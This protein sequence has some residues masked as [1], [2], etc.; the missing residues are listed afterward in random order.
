MDCDISELMN[1][2]VKSYNISSDFPDDR[3]KSAPP[4]LSKTP[5]L[6][7]GD[8]IPT[9][10]TSSNTDTKPPPPP[11]LSEAEDNSLNTI[12]T[13]V[14]SD[15]V[16]DVMDDP[17]PP[18]QT[19]QSAP[20]VPAYPAPL[21]DPVCTSAAED[22]TNKNEA[23]ETT[24]EEGK[25]EEVKAENAASCSDS[26]STTNGV[27]DVET[28]QLSV[29]SPPS[30]QLETPPE[31]PIAQPEE[32]CLPNG[33]PLPAPQDPEVSNISTVERDDSPIAEPEISQEPILQTPTAVTQK[34]PVPV[35]QAVPE[36]VDPP[37]PAVQEIP[38]DPVVQAPPTPPEVQDTVPPVDMDIEENTP[39]PQSAAKEEKPSPEE[40]VSIADTTSETVPTSSPPTAE[41]REN[42]P[43]P[44]TVVP[45][46]V[47]NTM[48]GQLN[49]AR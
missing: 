15:P 34:A 35:V 2:T 44:Q 49:T 10:T 8:P 9:E 18:T 29:M 14:P 4:P 3:G 46:I 30:C 13:L 20:E 21:P 24:E 45:T 36:L 42:T 17:P 48:Q 40:T 47:E 12:P 28:E 43:P 37:A 25:E 19:P 27:A 31:S 26:L 32:L 16:A 41:E 6:S 38:A 39:V 23:T 5:E 33:L 7:K 11:L 22:Q 1:W